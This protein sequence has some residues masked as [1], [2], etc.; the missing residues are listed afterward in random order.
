MQRIN[1]QR[2]TYY[3]DKI[4]L[5]PNEN[6]LIALA[7]E[8]GSK[9]WESELDSNYQS[10]FFHGIYSTPI[11]LGDVVL[12]SNYV[13]KTEAFDI[14]SGKKKWQQYISIK[15][16]PFIFEKVMFAVTE[17]QHLIALTSDGKL[18]WRVPIDKTNY[19]PILFNN[20][21]WLF[22]DKGKAYGYRVHTGKQVDK[23]DIPKGLS[24]PPFILD[25]LIYSFDQNGNLLVIGKK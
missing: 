14:E 3:K 13:G 20:L 1:N 10:S 21:L 2:P 7:A 12:S 24:Y 23:I 9:L 16:K 5:P 18:K 11:I 17:D 22:D 19:G 15:N 6:E 25:S 8:D 4:I